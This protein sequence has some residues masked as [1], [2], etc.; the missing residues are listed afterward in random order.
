MQTGGPNNLGFSSKEAITK[1]GHS[2]CRA[3]RK[4]DMSLKVD[5]AFV[6]AN[7]LG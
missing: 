1:N 7:E 5:V 3:A 6:V 2:S 4:I